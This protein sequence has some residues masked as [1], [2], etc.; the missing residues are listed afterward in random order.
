VAWWAWQVLPRREDP[1]EVWIIRSHSRGGYVR[2]VYTTKKGAQA[3]LMD[4]EWAEAW[5]TAGGTCLGALPPA[6][7]RCGTCGD[8]LEAEQ[9]RFCLACVCRDSAI[10][11][12]EIKNLLATNDRAQGRIDYAV[13]SVRRLA[14][15][16]RRADVWGLAG[17]LNGLADRLE[18]D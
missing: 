16:A 10:K 15:V 9:K 5:P 8:Q 12:R 3:S 4:G 18:K 7:W 13:A 14:N 11:N 17:D 6:S 2:A 1:A